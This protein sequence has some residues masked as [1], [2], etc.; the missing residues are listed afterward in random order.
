MKDVILRGFDASEVVSKLCNEMVNSETPYAFIKLDKYYLG[1][2]LDLKEDEV[3]YKLIIPE[4]DEIK[5]F[6]LD[7]DDDVQELQEFYEWVDL[8]IDE[9]ISLYVEKYCLNLKV[10]DY[11]PI[12]E[13]VAI[14]MTHQKGYLN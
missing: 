8:W 11:S 13:E 5:D 6:D 10:E 1:C 4:W 2:Y 9:G 12:T 7:N 14:N 3:G